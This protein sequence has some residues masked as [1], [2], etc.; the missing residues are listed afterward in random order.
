MD[1]EQSRVKAFYITD[2]PFMSG[3]NPGTLEHL[4]VWVM[5]SS[6]WT[7]SLENGR[8]DVRK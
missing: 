3:I 7:S 4:D 2:I 5:R 1:G 6:G 8:T